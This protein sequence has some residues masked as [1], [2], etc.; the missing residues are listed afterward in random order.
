M[1]KIDLERA[2]AVFR[3]ACPNKSVLKNLDELAD[4]VIS[5]RPTLRDKPF[6]IFFAQEK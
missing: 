5:K 3:L 4:L 1:K 2:I 6:S